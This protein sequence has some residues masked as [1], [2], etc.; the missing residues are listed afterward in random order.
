LSRYPNSAGTSAPAVAN[1]ILYDG[2]A[3]KLYAF[4]L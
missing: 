1:G 4:K 3:G 2:S